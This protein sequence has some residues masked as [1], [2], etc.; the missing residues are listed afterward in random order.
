VGVELVDQDERRRQALELAGV[1]GDHAQVAIARPDLAL[2]DDDLRIERPRDPHRVLVDHAGLLPTGRRDVD[3]RL[4]CRQQVVDGQSRED[5]RFAVAT[6]EQD[7]QLALGAEER[8]GDLLLER[9]R[10]ESGLLAQIEE[11]SELFLAF[12][13]D[14]GQLKQ[15]PGSHFRLARAGFRSR[16]PQRATR[17]SS[18]ITCLKNSRSDDDLGRPFPL[19]LRGAGGLTACLAN[20]VSGAD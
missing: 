8:R 19:L 2:V 20:A 7:E 16:P 12:R 5:E 10:L 1:R 15:P 17:R 4:R 11:G 13:L 9:H 14:S 18:A 6:R 3:P